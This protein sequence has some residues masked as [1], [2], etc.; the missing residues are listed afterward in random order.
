MSIAVRCPSHGG[1]LTVADNLA[2][3]KIKCPKCSAVFAVD[4]AREAGVSAEAPPPAPATEPAGVSAEAPPPA[5]ATEPAGI[6]PEALPPVEAEEVPLRPARIRRDIRQD[7][8][9][10]AVATL[11]PYRNARALIAYY[12]GVFSLIP[13]L[14]LVLGPVAFILGIL[15]LRYV[16]ANPGA[17]GTGHALAGIILGGLTGLVNWGVIIAG[18]VSAVLEGSRH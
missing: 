18:V 10:E 1:I 8:S 9:T 5:P 11:I 4:E 6:T 3:K 14:G 15:G 2:G 16:K 7:P 13:C 17:H 12:C